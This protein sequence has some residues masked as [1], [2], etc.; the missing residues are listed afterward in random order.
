MNKKRILLI[1]DEEDFIRMLKLNLEQSGKFEV[2]AL[3]EA[4]DVVA[5][6]HSFKPNVVLLDLIMPN[7]GG[8]EVCEMLN[9][10]P[11]GREVPII[12]LSALEKDVD[13][14]QAYKLGVVGYLVKPVETND[15][16]LAIGKAL[17][18]KQ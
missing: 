15:V 13:K 16:I 4:K 2:L 9:D 11:L 17:A 5:Q 10:D 3:T 6:V 1:D 7:I 8:M 14:L 18:Y 12:I